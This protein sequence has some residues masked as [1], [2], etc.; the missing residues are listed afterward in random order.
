[1]APAPVR[2]VVCAVDLSAEGDE[3]IRQ[4]HTL[5]K[6]YGAKLIG[7]HAM[8]SPAT[9]SPFFPTDVQAADTAFVG[10]ERSVLEALTERM[11]DVT[12]RGP[13]EFRVE[14][15]YGNPSSAILDASEQLKADLLVVGGAGP[16]ERVRRLLGAVAEDVARYAHCP[17]WVAHRGAGTGPVVAAT[18]FSKPADAALEAAVDFSRRTEAGLAVVHALSID[19][20]LPTGKEAWS[21]WSPDELNRMRADAKKH[22]SDVIART[23]VNAD[24]VVTDTAPAPA[25]LALAEQRQA[26]LIC[27]GTIGRTG[28]R[29]VVMGSVAEAVIRKAHCPVLVTRVE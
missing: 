3:A 22:L 19:H 10:L 18:D 12:G 1:M 15:G 26:R 28:L 25:V 24:P 14:L 27:V 4:A 11:L 7:F 16:S 6:L 29:R 5:A 17:V 2:T 23:G 13:H 20:V 21:V 9:A 8:P